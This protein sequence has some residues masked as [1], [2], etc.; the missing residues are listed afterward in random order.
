MTTTTSWTSPLS[1]FLD[2]A[3][4]YRRSTTEFKPPR[5]ALQLAVLRNAPAEP[6]GFTLAVFSSDGHTPDGEKR[7][8]VDNHGIV[9]VLQEADVNTFQSLVGTVQELPATDA[10]RNTWVLKY[11]RTS[12]P[13]ERI[14]VPKATLPAT[15]AASYEDEFAETSVQAFN[16]EE[17]QLRKPVHGVEVLPQSLWELTGSVLEARKVEGSEDPEVLSYVRGL[18]GNVF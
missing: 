17:R 9:H 11:Q 7:F 15:P 2:R 18:L 6:E 16:Y 10:F 14:L 12:Q 3:D 4:P 13:I 5:S 8:A 1:G